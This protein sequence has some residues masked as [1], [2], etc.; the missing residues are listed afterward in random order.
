[1]VGSERI[2][3]SVSMGHA[4]STITAFL[5]LSLELAILLLIGMPSVPSL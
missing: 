4:L 3:R 5:R 1:M 2:L